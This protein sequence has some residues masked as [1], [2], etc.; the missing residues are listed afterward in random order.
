VRDGK[1]P[2]DSKYPTLSKRT[3]VPWQSNGMGF[4]TIPGVR[5]PRVIQQPHAL[6]YG[7]DFLTRGLIT[8]EPPRKLGD[9]VALVPAN[10]K[11]GND[12]GCLLPPEVAVPLATY[13]G[14]NLRRKDAGADGQL[15]SLLGSYIPF[16]RTKAE[17]EKAADPR[18]SVEEHYADFEAY[19]RRFAG[20]CDALVKARYLV[21]EDAERLV[22]GREKLRGL[23]PASR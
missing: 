3:L 15:A 2:P 18:A 21:A 22:K 12:L 9:Y 16:P 17:R 23:F 8:N 4:P 14:W 7:P 5:V 13:T 20:A 6:D 1:L 11:D 19:R 10:D